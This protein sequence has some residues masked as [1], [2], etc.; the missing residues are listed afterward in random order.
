MAYT[1]KYPRPMV[2][3][4]ALVF[5]GTKPDLQVLLIQRGNEPFKGQWA[6]PG[7]FVDMDEALYD[8]VVRELKEETGLDVVDFRQLHTFGDPGRD[9]R[10]RNIST[11]F[12]THL[13]SPVEPK[14]GD[15]AALA[16]WFPMDELPALAFDHDEVI[17]MGLTQM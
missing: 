7:G 8:A 16:R 5:A 15:D 6:L 17:A 4:D 13:P 14:A 12:M 2:T 1:Y 10:G 11:V 3:V 9:P